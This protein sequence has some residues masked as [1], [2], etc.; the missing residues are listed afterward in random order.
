MSRHP[1]PLAVAGLAFVAGVVWWPLVPIAVAA[2]GIV[3]RGRPTM[4]ERGRRRRVAHALPDVVDLISIAISSGDTPLGSIRLIAAEGPAPVRAGFTAAVDHLAA[5]GTFSDAMQRSMTALGAEY[6][7][8]LVA[9]A[10][11]DREGAPL[12]SLLLRLSD[13]AVAARRH[14]NE[15]AARQLPV[16]L[17]LPLVL[18][19]LP[20]VVVGAVVPLLVVSLQRL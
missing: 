7:P 5:G 8:L 10:Q 16:Q 17:L 12:A 2:V 18:C 14:R 6:R 13:E 3:W 4:T 15:L 11:A 9:L 1:R 20:A 19:S